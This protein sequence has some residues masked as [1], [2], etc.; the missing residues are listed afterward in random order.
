MQSHPRSGTEAAADADAG[1]RADALRHNFLS[2][3]ILAAQ[4]GCGQDVEPFLALSWETWGEEQLWDAVKDLPHGCARKEGPARQHAAG[5]F[6][7]DLGPFSAGRT[8]VMFA[9]QAGDVARLR[10][11]IARGAELELKDWKGQTALFWASRK[12]RV[13]AVRELLARGAAADTAT[14]DGAT[15]L[16]VAIFFGCLEIARA[17]LVRGA[18]VD[19]ATN[20]GS[21]PLLIASERGHLEVVREL[22]ARGASPGLADMYGA[23]ALSRATAGGHAAIA[24]LLRAALEA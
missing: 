3:L 20:A 22:L 17:L 14:D 10:W 5:P 12:G 4:N 7:F 23:T 24:Q 9:A 16:Y 2:C 1:A 13:E 11:L 18:A 15:P 6:G 19:T 21:T 8:R